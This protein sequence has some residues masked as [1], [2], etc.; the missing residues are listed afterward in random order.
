MAA[1]NVQYFLRNLSQ[2]CGYKLVRKFCREICVNLKIFDMRQTGTL[3]FKL[4][5]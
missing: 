2:E 4:C 3:I 1:L 5:I